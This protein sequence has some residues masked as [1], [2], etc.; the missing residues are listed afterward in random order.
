MFLYLLSILCCSALPVAALWPQPSVYT[1]G[2]DG[3]NAIWIDDFLTARFYCNG[4]LLFN[5]AINSL[6]QTLANPAPRLGS[7]VPTLPAQ[8]Y[9]PVNSTTNF[10]STI[11]NLTEFVIAQA[12]V[13]DALT[14]VQT[15]SFVPWKFHHRGIVFEP[16]PD[17]ITQTLSA[18]DITQSVCP[19]SD[20]ALNPQA[21]FAG[22]EAYEI[23]VNGT[24]AEIRSNTTLGT[25]RGL[26][27]FKQL[28]Y[29]HS[30][31]AKR[32]APH[33]PIYV[34][35][36][37]KWSHRGLSLDIARSSYTLQDVMRVIDAMASAKFS[38]LHVHATDS[39]AWPIEIP[40]LPGLAEK[41]AYHPSLIWQTDAVAQLQAY[42]AA[43]GVSVFLEIDMPGH[44]GSIA[45]A[46]PDLIA[47]FN[48]TDWQTFAAEPNS[49]QLKLNSTAVTDF[50]NKLFHDLLPR[51]KQYTQIHHLGGDEFNK[52]VYLLDETVKSNNSQILQPLVQAFM[53]NVLAH[54]QSNGLRPMVWQ[55]QILEW[56]ITLPTINSTQLSTLVQVWINSD[57]IDNVLKKGHRVIFGDYNNW[58]LDCGYGTFINPYPSGVSP[59][60]VPYGTNGS[61]PT[62]IKDPFLDYC[63]PVKNWR[64]V[65]M[66]NPLQNITSSLQGMVEGGEVLLWS[67]Q[68]DPIDVD[69]KLWPRAAAAAE[70][71]WSGPRDTS[72]ID[73]ASRRLG[74]WRER[75][76]LD[77]GIGSSPVQMSWCLME[78]GCQA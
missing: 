58:Y 34:Y 4:S 27:T 37:P 12:A 39:Q 61:V 43:K 15:T 42:G 26:E 52:N 60:G 67:E 65:Y 3:T 23:Y 75:A 13:Q 19:P 5:A 53:S 50:V 30:S 1:K 72:M 35:D 64:H 44:T 38:R 31:T 62:I 63:S 7:S 11:N 74:Q 71:L 70:V 47:A 32:Y 2:S 6:H 41:G 55:E 56:N 29:A 20:T 17:N 21:Y 77:L 48:Q 78:G 24:N 46:Y 10:T 18:I 49:G 25:L 76:V 66:Y 22:N 54:V 36:S 33:I 59:P 45:F 57:N 14:A 69:A 9:M 68:T 28:F 8:L 40:A 16:N 73:E 51:L